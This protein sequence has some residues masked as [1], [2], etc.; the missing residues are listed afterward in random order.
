MPVLLPSVRRALAVAV[1]VSALAASAGLSAASAHEGHHSA[2]YWFG[3]PGKT[4]DVDRTIRVEPK[5]LSFVPGAREVKRGETMA[6]AR[7]ARL[8][9]CPP[10]T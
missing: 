1:A 9:P 2:T 7:G 10:L 6:K 5:D 8:P 4:A 3:A